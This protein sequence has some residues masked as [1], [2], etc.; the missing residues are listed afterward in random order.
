MNVFFV[1]MTKVIAFYIAEKTPLINLK[2]PF[3]KPSYCNIT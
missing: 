2:L 1:A 3:V